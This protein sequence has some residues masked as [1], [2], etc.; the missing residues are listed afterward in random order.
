MTSDMIYAFEGIQVKHI[1]GKFEEALKSLN[2]FK[3]DMA[4]LFDTEQAFVNIAF[5]H[6]VL[7][8]GYKSNIPNI[9]ELYKTNN[10]VNTIVNIISYILEKHIDY[11]DLD[12]G[13]V[14]PQP[15]NIFYYYTNK[16]LEE[17]CVYILCYLLPCINSVLPISSELR[18]LMNEKQQLKP[19]VDLLKRELFIEKFSRHFNE[20]FGLLIYTLNWAS[21][22]AE[23]HKLN[24][25]EL[26]I[27]DTLFKYAKKYEKYGFYMYM[28]AANIAYDHEIETYSDML[29]ALDRFVNDSITCIEIIGTQVRE[30]QFTD[31][32]DPEKKTHSFAVTYIL[33]EQTH[34]T[35][36]LT[37]LLLALYRFSVNAKIK[38]DL[39]NRPNLKEAI[40]RAV[41]E[42]SDIEKQHA[43]QLLAQLSFD[44]KVNADLRKDRDLYDDVKFMAEDS[45]LLFKK[46]KK[47]SEQL[48][49]ILSDK[50][51][52]ALTSSKSSSDIA[53]S[54][55]ISSLG[56]HLMISYN[57]GSRDLCLKIK[58]SLEDLNFK[59]WIDID[60]TRKI[61]D[62]IL[63][64]S[65]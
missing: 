53:N 25:R 46:L 58:K 33:D 28:I 37:G 26:S 44:E 63:F 42:G 50:G 29:L 16:N 61:F 5:M 10:T 34:V 1:P 47:S 55:K 51:S 54:N 14:R 59:I 35:V 40:K 64:H 57:T 22:A 48:V 4:C 39:Y 30:Q 56:G 32:D 31:E 60:E 45:N 15:E 7:R 38:W 2:S 3:D 17:K 9:Y 8:S 52:S 18:E 62:E 43:I 65:K 24:W 21:K 41:H 11:I 19:L 20:Y 27:V 23:A 36:S 12:R 6:A 13:F 49:W